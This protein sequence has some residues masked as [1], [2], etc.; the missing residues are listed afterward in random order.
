MNRPGGPIKMRSTTRLSAH[1]P[2]KTCRKPSLPSAFSER[3]RLLTCPRMTWG[4]NFRSLRPAFRS[5]HSR[6]GRL[7]T[8]AT[9]STS[10]NLA[11]ATNGFLASGWTFVASITVSF[12]AFSLLPAMNCSVSNASADAAWSF[13]SSLTSAT[14]LKRRCMRRRVPPAFGCCPAS[15]DD[16][17]R[18]I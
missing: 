11:S 18:R 17:A 1:C 16:A 15:R 9:G 6:C 14:S 3:R 12:P 4:P 13:S 7:R 10:W 2:P 5:W 8:I